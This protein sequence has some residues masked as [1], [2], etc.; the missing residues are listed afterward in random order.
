MLANTVTKRTVVRTA[1]GVKPHGAGNVGRLARAKRPSLVSSKRNDVAGCRGGVAAQSMGLNE[2]ALLAELPESQVN[3]I[4]ETAGV[5]FA[6]T[7]TGLA[8]G[9][10]LL[11][12]ESL[13]EAGNRE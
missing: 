6:I 11:R 10:V 2:V 13:V 3:E 7:L 9:F 5:M 8:L 12:V 4:F 1:A